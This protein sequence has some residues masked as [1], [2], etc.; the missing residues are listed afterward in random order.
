MRQNREFR[1]NFENISRDC[2]TMYD[3]RESFVSVSHDDPTNECVALV[4]FS[5]VRHSRDIR[6]S[7]SQHFERMSLSSRQIFVM[8]LHVFTSLSRDWRTTTQIQNFAAT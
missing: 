6:E 8:C 7:V 5:F 4:S 2:R 3:S 1:S